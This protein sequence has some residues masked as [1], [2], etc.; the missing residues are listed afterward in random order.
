VE[1]ARAV[2]K[3]AIIAGSTPLAKQLETIAAEMVA[4]RPEVKKLTPVRRFVEYFSISAARAA[5][6]E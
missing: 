3:G 2:N 1:I 6:K 5:Q 4:T